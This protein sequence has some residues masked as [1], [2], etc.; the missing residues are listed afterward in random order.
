MSRSRGPG[1]C[2]GRIS[3]YRWRGQQAQ[4]W[5]TGAAQGVGTGY[6]V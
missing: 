5:G 2:D 4:A 1:P 6:R 3:G